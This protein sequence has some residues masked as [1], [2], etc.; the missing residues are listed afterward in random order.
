MLKENSIV[1]EKNILTIYE[2]SDKIY[3]LRTVLVVR[4][5]LVSVGFYQHN[6]VFA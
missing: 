6:I 4:N 2:V 1:C 5:T 3:T